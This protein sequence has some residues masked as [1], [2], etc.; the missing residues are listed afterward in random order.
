[1]V[2][3]KLAYKMSGTKWKYLMFESENDRTAALYAGRWA[4]K[5]N[6]DAFQLYKVITERLI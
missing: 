5:N 3:Y 1:M 6:A 2:E 4:G